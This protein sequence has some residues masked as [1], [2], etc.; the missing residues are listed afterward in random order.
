M[1]KVKRK[2]DMLS[3]EKRKA[4]IEKTITFFSIEHDQELG[5]I[6]AES[7]LDFFLQN[8]GE[9]I[10]NRGIENAKQLLKERFCDLEVE[11]DLLLKK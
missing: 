1:K 5:V 4:C 10:Y 2:W 9:E 6:A 11:L 7:I 8:A 3:E